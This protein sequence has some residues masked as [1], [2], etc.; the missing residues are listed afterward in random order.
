MYAG[1]Q[2]LTKSKN[3]DIFISQFL[4]LDFG[5]RR[6]ITIRGL[7]FCFTE[8]TPVPDRPGKNYGPQ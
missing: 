6:I 2:V 7:I 5:Q 4:F 1:V 8:T 3:K